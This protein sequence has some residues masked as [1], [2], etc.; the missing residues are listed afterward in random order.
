VTLNRTDFVDRGT[1]RTSD[2]IIATIRATQAASITIFGVSD[3]TVQVLLP[4]LYVRQAEVAAG[5]SLLFPTP[6]QRR[7]MGLVVNAQV[8]P[9]RDRITELY[10]VV[11]TRRPVPFEGPRG[12]QNGGVSTVRGTLS[13]L[14][15]WLVNIPLNERAVAFAAYEVRRQ[16]AS[17]SP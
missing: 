3:D 12:V 2:E 10:V 4:N 5:D 13:A 11:A 7:Q 15:R 14:N 8:P 6:T 17:G 9:G 16:R 1:A